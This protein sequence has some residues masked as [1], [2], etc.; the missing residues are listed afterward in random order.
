MFG[1]IKLINTLKIE[2]E[3]ISNLISLKMWDCLLVKTAVRAADF[4]VH[5][6]LE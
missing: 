5:L 6:L 2:F 3:I 1:L 4:I